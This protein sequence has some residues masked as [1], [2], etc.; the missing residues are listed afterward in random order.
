MDKDSDGLISR[1]EIRLDGLLEGDGGL[2]RIASELQQ[3]VRLPRPE[4]ASSSVS[5]EQSPVRRARLVRR[6][7][8]ARLV[9]PA[10]EVQVV[11]VAGESAGTVP[12]RR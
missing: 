3:V 8:R 7:R 10:S 11:T 5:P 4:E 12:Q 6:R 1:D 2:G 9:I